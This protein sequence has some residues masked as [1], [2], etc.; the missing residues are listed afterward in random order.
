MSEVSV[1]TVSPRTTTQV[2]I[3]GLN[4]PTYLGTELAQKPQVVLKSGSTMTGSL[5]LPGNAA[6]ALE[7]VPKQQLDA[8]VAGLTTSINAIGS[9]K[10]LAANG[11]VVLPGGVYMQ[12]FSLTLTDLAAGQGN[13]LY[14]TT[15]P[16]AFPNACLHC[17][18]SLVSGATSPINLSVAISSKTTT[19]INFHAEEW[20]NSVNPITVSFLAIGY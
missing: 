4:P 18:T 14:S 6:A 16:V 13:N 19:G 1:N 3:T 15:F 20:S 10:S 2:N 12:W 11:Y 8:A 7:A 17:F 5:T 9:V